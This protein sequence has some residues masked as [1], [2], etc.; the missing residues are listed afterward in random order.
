MTRKKQRQG[1]SVFWRSFEA[2][3]HSLGHSDPDFVSVES[4]NVV[5]KPNREWKHVFP[6]KRLFL[7]EG[8][9]IFNT[10]RAQQE[11]NG[12]RL[13]IVNNTQNRWAPRTPDLP[14]KERSYRAQD[15]IQPVRNLLGAV[16]ATGR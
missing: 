12:Q 5:V 7:Q 3:F 1:L 4:D 2:T 16:K 14:R 8:Q 13:S 15:C 6:E 10:I 11:S 9:E